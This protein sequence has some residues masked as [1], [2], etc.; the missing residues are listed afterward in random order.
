MTRIP[1]S[2]GLV[3]TPNTNTR[4]SR[5]EECLNRFRARRR[6]QG[7]LIR[8][9]DEYLFLGGIDASQRAFQGVDPKEYAAATA[10]EKQQLSNVYGIHCSSDNPKYFNPSKPEHWSVDFS[11]VVAGYLSEGIP[12]LTWT[13]R[14]AEVDMQRA[15]DVV[16]NF[17][18]YLLQHDVCNE[19]EDDIANALALCE[20]GKEELPLVHGVIK[21]LPCLFNQATAEVAKSGTNIM[22]GDEPPTDT[23][24]VFR[25]GLSFFGPRDACKKVESFKVIRTV[26]EKQ[27]SLEIV[28]I[29]P[30]DER[31]VQLTRIFGVTTE[32]R[33]AIKAGVI[34]CKHVHIR[35]E[36]CRGDAE[37]ELPDRIE[38]LVIQSS[39]LDFLRPGFIIRVTL[40]ELNIGLKYMVNLPEIL[41]SFYRFLPQSLMRK[42]K[43][44]APNPRPAPSVLG[45]VVEEYQEQDQ[46]AED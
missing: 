42:Y 38:V 23:E 13:R 4:C 35:D 17:L 20:R 2:S 41:P 10:E 31:T 34:R 26:A 46:E 21:K 9:F 24:A 16:A 30:P 39:I 7:D 37:S 36:L 27:C 6:L 8:Y 18:R 45:P 5:I 1:R 40:G 15:I 22:E 43:F 12:Y 11:A 3:V 33:D 29:H 14:S 44:P 28:S 32:V 19:Y 25:F